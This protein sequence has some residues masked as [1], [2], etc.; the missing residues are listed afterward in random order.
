MRTQALERARAR[1]IKPRDLKL[2]LHP[3]VPH[4]WMG[5]D[6]YMTHLMN[7]MSVTFPHGERFFMD[8]VRDL[9]GRVDDPVLAAQVRGFLAQ[10][11]LHRREHSH[12]NDWLLQQG[13]PID[14]YEAEVE[15]LLPSR[16]AFSQPMIRLAV[17][18]AL[19]HF[20]AI[21]ADAWLENDELREL[22]D[23]QV[24]KLWIWHA[25]EELDHK[26]VAFDVYRAAGGWYSMRVVTMLITTVLFSAK[27]TQLQIRL[28]RRDRQLWNLK[29][30]FKGVWRFWGPRGYFTRL[31]PAYLRYYHPRFHPWDHDD[32]EAITRFERPFLGDGG[33]LSV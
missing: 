18:C 32:N 12:L 22:C 13:F 7:A 1:D 30:W 20:T 4:H 19:E 33:A 31:L 2:S 3:D 21:M 24:R 27:V 9:R 8:A 11:A 16:G 28:M 26:S 14:R 6:P 5:G 10:E 29:S 23:P 25:L 15:R 17:T